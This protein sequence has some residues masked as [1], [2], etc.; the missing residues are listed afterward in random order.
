VRIQRM[1]NAGCGQHVNVVETV[2]SYKPEVT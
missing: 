1:D 2:G